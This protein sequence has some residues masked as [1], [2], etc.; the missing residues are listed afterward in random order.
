MT[1]TSPPDDGLYR[2]HIRIPY[3]KGTLLVLSPAEFLLAL[4]RGKLVKRQAQHA[5]R[6][7]QTRQ[8]PRS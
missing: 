6:Q 7:A 3:A 2:D 1:D 8:E 4:R 5:R